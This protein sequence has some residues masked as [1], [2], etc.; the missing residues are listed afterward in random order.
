MGVNRRRLLEY[1][2]N[3]AMRANEMTNCTRLF[4]QRMLRLGLL[5]DGEEDFVC[6][7]PGNVVGEELSWRDPT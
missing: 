2:V 7:V 3:K 4:Y 5:D 6:H 1:Q